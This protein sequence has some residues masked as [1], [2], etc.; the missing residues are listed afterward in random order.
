M[1]MKTSGEIEIQDLRIVPETQIRMNKIRRMTNTKRALEG[2]VNLIENHTYMECAFPTKYD[3]GTGKPLEFEWRP[4]EESGKFSYEINLGGGCLIDPV[5]TE[6]GLSDGI[7]KRIK[8][9]GP[10]LVN[11][12]SGKYV[13]RYAEN[14]TPSDKSKSVNVTRKYIAVEK[15]KEVK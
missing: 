6:L 10:Y 8:E 1:I 13:F 11:T 9:H 14:T 15:V 5:N 3:E 12:Q 4:D 7:V 2:V